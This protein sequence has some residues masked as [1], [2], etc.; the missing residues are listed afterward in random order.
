M[1]HHI[2]ISRYDAALKDISRAIDLD[3]TLV[4]ERAPSLARAE[5]FILRAKLHWAMG[6]IDGGIQDM[7]MAMSLAPEHIEVRRFNDVMQ[8][9]VAEL[10]CQGLDH[11]LHHEFP[12]AIVLFTAAIRIAPNDVKL[13]VTRA[14][15]YRQA[16]SCD[17]ALADISQ[18]STM[19]HE[20]TMPFFDKSV[21]Q[22]TDWSTCNCE[23]YRHSPFGSIAR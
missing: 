14:S 9:K 20:G 7:T 21:K 5:Q 1:R 2:D 15:A 12:D 18:A 11:M 13:L 10:Y 22:I 3:S 19:F 6:L 16:G 8:L 4:P 23:P 17:A